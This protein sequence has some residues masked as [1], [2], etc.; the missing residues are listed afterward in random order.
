MSKKEFIK[1]EDTRYR[2]STIKRFQPFVMFRSDK[3]FGVYIYFSATDLNKR[4]YHNFETES[5]RDNILEELDQI[6]E[7]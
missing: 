2:S 3:L 1:I 5:E 4:A 6:F 7:I